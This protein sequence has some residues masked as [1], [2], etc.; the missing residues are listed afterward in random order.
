MAPPDPPRNRD[1]LRRYID[2][3]RDR[4]GDHRI[5]DLLEEQLEDG[6]LHI[7]D[8]TSQPGETGTDGDITIHPNG[9]SSS[10]TADDPCYWLGVLVHEAVHAFMAGRSHASGYRN[11]L[12]QARRA[13]LGRLPSNRRKEDALAMGVALKFAHEHCM[14]NGFEK[15]HKVPNE[16]IECVARQCYLLPTGELQPIGP[17]PHPPPQYPVPEPIPRA[18]EPTPLPEPTPEPLP[19]PDPVPNPVPE[20]SPFPPL[21]PIPEMPPTGP[22]VPEDDFEKPIR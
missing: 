1:D 4:L 20:E 10:H 2:V 3:L 12:Q 17:G 18:P 5:I 15:G 13:C 22:V 16:F 6:S 21:P 9:A 14:G 11:L 7:G 19:D 8:G